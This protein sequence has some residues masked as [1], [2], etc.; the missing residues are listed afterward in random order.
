MAIIFLLNFKGCEIWK[1]CSVPKQVKII[2]VYTDDTAQKDE[3]NENNVKIAQK[4]PESANIVNHKKEKAAS[5]ENKNRLKY[6]HDM[7][8]LFS[9]RN[10]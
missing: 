6:L 5:I 10:F 7:Y 4:A 8:E 3:L 9:L 1:I 2:S